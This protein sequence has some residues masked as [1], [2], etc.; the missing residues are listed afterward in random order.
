MNSNPVNQVLMTRVVE[1][2]VVGCESWP[3]GC[4]CDSKYILHDPNTGRED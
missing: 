1:A 3:D 2:F 4:T